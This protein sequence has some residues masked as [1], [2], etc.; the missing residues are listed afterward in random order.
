MNEAES[1]STFNQEHQQTHLFYQDDAGTLYQVV[2]YNDG[3]KLYWPVS[4]EAT[5]SEPSTSSAIVSSTSSTVLEIE[6]SAH[7]QQTFTINYE[8]MYPGYQMD[9]SFSE[10]QSQQLYDES[11]VAAASNFEKTYSQQMEGTEEG[12]SHQVAPQDGSYLS[13]GDGSREQCH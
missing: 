5:A 7:Q 8:G 10:H 4:T 12:V 3:S 11:L 6:P 2:Q 1:T 13:R 9:S